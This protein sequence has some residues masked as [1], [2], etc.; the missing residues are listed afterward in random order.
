MP[1]AKVPTS[2]AY[3][4][5][6]WRRQA[7]SK[8]APPTPAA[9]EG[10]TV[11]LV[12]ATGVILSDAARILSNLKIDTLIF[13]VRN[14]KKGEALADTLR[15]KHA[16]VDFKTW[17]IDLFSF[18][19]V[20]KFAAMINDYG[21]ID[22]I[23]MGSAIMNEETKMTKDGW[24]ETLQLVHLSAALLFALILPKLLAHA[25]DPTGLPPV[26]LSNVSSLSIRSTSP[27]L[28]L[29]AT[30]AES[31]L[32]HLNR[33]DAT[34]TERRNQYGYA[35]ILQTCWLRDLCARLPPAPATGPSRST[36]ST[37]AS[38]PRPSASSASS[39]RSSCCGPAGPSR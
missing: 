25:E 33:A 8:L 18:E 24:E 39:P 7:K 30:P 17:E 13:G 32:G 28:K 38:A 29:P 6:A 11:L 31:Y 2:E 37:R 27:F 5:K 26:V 16:D 15:P 22:A 10:K 21:R 36:R 9:Y 34:A 20:K 19:S 12:G 14:V 1:P 3:P 4:L 23:V 35:K